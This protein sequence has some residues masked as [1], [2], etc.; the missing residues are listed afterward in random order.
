MRVH[1]GA[2][3]RVGLPERPGDREA[4]DV[5]G[6]LEREGSEE[7]SMKKKQAWR[8]VKKHE[9]CFEANLESAG[10]DLMLLSELQKSGVR[11]LR[12]ALREHRWLLKYARTR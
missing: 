8:E 7:D 2:R 10:N 4:D 6:L 11:A 12:A 9:A 1:S 3:A 5:P